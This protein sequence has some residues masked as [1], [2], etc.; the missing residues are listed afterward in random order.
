MSSIVV[1]W[2][3]QPSESSMWSDNRLHYLGHTVYK[4]ECIHGIPHVPLHTLPDRFHLYVATMR[5]FERGGAMK[6][7]IGSSWNNGVNNHLD[8]Y[9][10]QKR[11]SM[12]MLIVF[13]WL[14]HLWTPLRPCLKQIFCGHTHAHIHTHTWKHCFTP[15]AHVR[16]GWLVCLVRVH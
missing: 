13:G 14:W 8:L 12:I 3:V 4:L 2:S 10:V 1:H 5:D 11:P 7:I 6:L 9:Q 16:A 15:A